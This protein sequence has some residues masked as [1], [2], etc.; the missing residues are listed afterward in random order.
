MQ[1]H[2]D[3]IN[4]TNSFTLHQ[5]RLRGFIR[6]AGGFILRQMPTTNASLSKY[7][8]LKGIKE[9]VLSALLSLGVLCEASPWD[10]DFS[11]LFPLRLSG[12]T[13]CIDLGVLGSSIFFSELPSHCTTIT[14]E[15]QS[16]F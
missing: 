1:N 15:V 5:S 6:L 7:L 12:S 11:F 8:P 4:C 3:F 14:C 16:Q 13:L 2:I 10:G 9:R